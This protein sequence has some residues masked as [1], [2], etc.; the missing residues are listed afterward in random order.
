MIET[1][2]AAITSLKT[3]IEIT[4]FINSNEN[5]EKLK[6]RTKELINTI[7]NLQHQMLSIQSDH[8]KLL[9]DNDNMRKK[10]MKL[11]AWDKE[12][13]NYK[14]TEICP[15]VFVYS[16]KKTNDN[17]DPEHWL[18]QKCYNHNK[19]S[20]LQF[21]GQSVAGNIYICHECNNEICDQRNR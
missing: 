6:E 17:T 15:G 5:D 11:E 16:Y 9:Q 1:V 8:G 4:K 21:D 12:K 7:I 19:K 20:I 13:S 18:C 14:L 2:Q 3:V 10:L